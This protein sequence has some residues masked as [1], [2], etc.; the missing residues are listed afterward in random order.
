MFFGVQWIMKEDAS[1]SKYYVKISS[2]LLTWILRPPRPRQALDLPRQLDESHDRLRLLRP[3]LL[4]TNLFVSTDVPT[5]GS[6]ANLPP[7]D[8]QAVRGSSPIHS[9]VQALALIGSAIVSV[10]VSGGLV[11]AFK[12]RFNPEVRCRQTWLKG[13]R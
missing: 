3:A 9:G 11:E 2:Q 13:Q 12:G 1:I 10:I 8:F 5:P 4:R 6:C 7:S